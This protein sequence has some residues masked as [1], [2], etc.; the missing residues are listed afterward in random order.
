[1]ISGVAQI[2]A[3]CGTWGHMI[4]RKSGGKPPHSKGAMKLKAPKV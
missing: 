1:V 3:G 4:V 2:V